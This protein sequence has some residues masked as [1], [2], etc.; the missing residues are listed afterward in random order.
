MGQFDNPPTKD[1]GFPI[2]ERDREFFKNLLIGQEVSISTGQD[3]Q[4][5]WYVLEKDPDTFKI[6]VRNLLKEKL[7]LEIDKVH[8][9]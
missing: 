4:E 6:T 7:E 5:G 1:N 3:R 2:Q 8:S 9:I